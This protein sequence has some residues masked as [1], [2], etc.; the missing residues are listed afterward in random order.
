[1]EAQRGRGG[2][3]GDRLR[4]RLMRR[5]GLELPTG[6]DQRSVPSAA[7]PRSYAVAWCDDRRAPLLL[8]LHGAGGTG[9][10]MAALTGLA[11]RGPAAGFT[12]VFP[13]GVAHVWNDAR[14]APGLARR[15]GVDDVG[16]LV[17]MIEQLDAEREAGGPVYLTGM[18]NGAL[19]SESMARRAQLDVAGLAVVAG[20]GTATARDAVPLPRQAARVVLF[21]GTA[22]PLV[23]YAGGPITLPWLRGR[24]RRA[25]PGTGRRGVAAPA[26]AV[27]G[28]WAHANRCDA[29]PSS[30]LLAIG[31]HLPVTRVTWR[32]GGA[33]RVD[34][35]RIDGGGHTWPGGGRYLPERLV[36]PVAHRLDATAILLDTF[37]PGG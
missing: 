7:G 21:A 35:Y 1:M 10:G 27:A 30:E 14:Q 31:G 18:S 28:D 2:A 17:A 36:G 23:P 33:P 11:T 22:D 6:L 13:D 19:L 20:S 8:A 32:A 34:L 16:F 37:R 26:E 5:A 15:T 3:R 24:G 12:A 4:Q 9:P 29:A 25:G